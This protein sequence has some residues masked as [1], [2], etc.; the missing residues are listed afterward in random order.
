MSKI[1]TGVH[2]QTVE[3]FEHHLEKNLR[4]LAHS[5]KDGSYRIGKDEV[6]E[7]GTRQVIKAPRRKVTC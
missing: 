2:H 7:S 6:E 5:L 4:R 1:V 3:M